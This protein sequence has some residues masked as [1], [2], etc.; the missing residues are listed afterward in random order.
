VEHEQVLSGTTEQAVEGLR[1]YEEW[2]GRRAVRI[3]SASLPRHRVA[4]AERQGPVPEA[5]SIAVET[6][7]L[8]PRPGRPTGR[9]FGRLVHDILQRADRVEDV[10]ALARIWGR[11]HGVN[12]ADSEAAAAVALSALERIAE[13][14]P[15]GARRL[16]ETPLLVRLANGTLVDGRI[17]FA[18]SDGSRWTVV[19]Y[20]TD[21]R[22]RRQVGQLQLY[23]LALQQA[24]G[25]PARG[26]VLEV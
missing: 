9:H 14:V 10:P 26:I 23:A 12:D 25:Q 20:K 6:I 18:W 16:R 11:R 7:T 15:K 2:K 3:E 4:T 8:P 19:D 17:D 1:R 22:E 21:R 24:T 13:L 5:E